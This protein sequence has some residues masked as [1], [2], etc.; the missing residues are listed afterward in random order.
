MKVLVYHY[1]QGEKRI[2]AELE[3]KD[4]QLTISGDAAE[5][6]R[7]DLEKGILN[8]AEGKKERVYPDNPELLLKNMP[9]NY[10]SSYMRAEL[11]T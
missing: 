7:A 9:Y 10:S 6:L 3:I 5:G 11:I 8:L 4:G 1:G 2:I